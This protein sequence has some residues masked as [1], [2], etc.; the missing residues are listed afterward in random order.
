V[1]LTDI[2]AV[3]RYV[4]VTAAGDQDGLKADAAVACQWVEDQAGPI[5]QRTVTERAWSSGWYIRLSE[6]PAKITSI[7]GVTDGLDALALVPGG[8]AGAV[9]PGYRVVVYEVGSANPPGW[10][11]DA[12]L[13]MTKHLWQ[14]RLGAK[15][16]Q[17]S[18]DYY[19]RATTLIEAHQRGPRP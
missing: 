12:A 18:I 14:A 6:T 11:V 8:A 5:E 13:A 15:G 16:S 7:D 9:I 1:Y 2:E 17:Q 19:A 10:A 3:A 4:G